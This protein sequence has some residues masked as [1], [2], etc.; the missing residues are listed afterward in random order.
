M[1]YQQLMAK[2]R[3]LDEAYSDYAVMNMNKFIDLVVMGTSIHPDITLKLLI[4]YKELFCAFHEYMALNDMFIEQEYN[5]K[6]T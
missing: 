4:E 3:E 5:D 2:Y 6:N 1:D